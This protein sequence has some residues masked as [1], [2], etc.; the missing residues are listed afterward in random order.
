MQPVAQ[1][2]DFDIGEA[3][4]EGWR[5]LWP[6]ILP[7]ASFA[8]IAWA[9]NLLSQVLQ[10][11][12]D[13]FARFLVSLVAFVVSQFVAIG[14]ITIAL[15]IVDGRRITAAA[16]TDRFR[17][18]VPYLIASVIYGVM[19]GVG[20]VLL[21]VPGI[22]LAIIFA[23]YG[24]HIIDTSESNPL[25]ALGRSAEITRGRRMKLFGFGVVLVLLNILGLLVFLV[26]VLITSGISLIAGAHVYRSLSPAVPAGPA[27][28][29]TD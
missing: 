1:P 9:I 18:V 12:V 28:G 14:W 26:G 21:I 27:P 3:I 24:F 10:Q 29:V 7:M 15:D 17:L 5:R 11:E 13:G 6:N 8:V 20:L 19:V 22:I 4:S 23:F 16:V 2:G 25:A